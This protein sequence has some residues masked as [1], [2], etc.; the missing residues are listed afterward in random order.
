[1]AEAVRSAPP[2]AAA[3]Q[4]AHLATQLAAFIQDM[5][6][7]DDITFFLMNKELK[8]MSPAK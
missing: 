2:S 3:K 1:L 8:S 6:P 7:F 5:P 4:L